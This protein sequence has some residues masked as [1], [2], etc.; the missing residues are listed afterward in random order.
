MPDQNLLNYIK[1]ALAQGKSRQEITATLMA[2]GGWTQA[3]IDAVFA[4]LPPVPPSAPTNPQVPSFKPQGSVPPLSPMNVYTVPG[5]G[6]NYRPQNSGSHWLLGLITL[7]VAL[8]GTYFSWYVLIGNSTVALWIAGSMDA[9]LLFEILFIWIIAALF[10]VPN[11]SFSKPLLIGG[12]LGVMYI[13]VLFLYYNVPVFSSIA[14]VV[15]FIIYIVLLVKIYGISIGKSIGIAVVA[16]IPTMIVA[17]VI[18]MALLFKGLFSLV[19]VAEN[20]N[21]QNAQI[22][23]SSASSVMIDS[24]SLTTSSA[25]PTI[26]GMTANLS[27]VSVDVDG[28]VPAK[29]GTVALYDGTVPVV[30]GA[31]S[32]TVSASNAA[33]GG[34]QGLA[35]GNYTVVVGAT[36]A[37]ALASSTL[38]VSNG[39]QMPATSVAGMQQY[40][41]PAW[42][43]TISYPS[44]FAPTDTLT[45]AQQNSVASYMGT[46]SVGPAGH[47]NDVAQVQLCYIGTQKPDGFASA[48]VNIMPNHAISAQD[49]QKPEDSGNTSSLAS[50]TATINGATFYENTF[51][52]AAL[53]HYLSIDSYRTY[54]GGTCYTVD[55]KFETDRGTSEKG[56][57]DPSF[58]ATMQAKLKAILSTIT[59]S[60]NSATIN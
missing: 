29:G 8:V 7:A 57:N 50:Q 52:D 38:T 56:L 10:R 58:A 46:C 55:L 40:S 36:E 31:W 28:F 43:F 42:P 14:G 12:V 54:Q 41:V 60:Q 33:F 59:F 44:D 13:P 4:T 20:Y 3:D 23:N 21:A 30:N 45:T 53:G 26:T 47:S 19:T 22:Q 2:Q 17:G 15:E 5:A 18:V 37:A 1:T 34:P 35:P 48:G 49:C 25:F 11:N 51:S 6:Q 27:S 39:S 24:D 32:F 16:G 9:I